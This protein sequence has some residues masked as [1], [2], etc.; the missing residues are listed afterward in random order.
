MQLTHFQ[1]SV[2]FLSFLCYLK[3]VLELNVNYGHFEF[4]EKPAVAIFIPLSIVFSPLLLLQGAG[5]V[6]S[7]FN[8]VEEY[9]TL[10]H[11]GPRTGRSFVISD[12][13]HD[14]FGH[15]YNGSR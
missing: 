9:V 11:N 6:L 2:F 7:A 4:Q 15:L 14:R 13:A 1:D 3:N 5:V 10:L 8:L 12:G